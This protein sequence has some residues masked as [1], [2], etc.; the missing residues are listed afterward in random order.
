MFYKFHNA[1][2][3]ITCE[4]T[5]GFL[6]MFH[7]YI[8]FSKQFSGFTKLSVDGA[9][10]FLVYGCTFTTRSVKEAAHLTLNKIIIHY[11]DE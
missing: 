2:D 6:F 3:L 7:L 10:I 8:I 1:Y 11:R 5:V 9:S 4:L